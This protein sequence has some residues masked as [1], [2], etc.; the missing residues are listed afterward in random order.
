MALRFSLR[1]RLTLILIAS[2]ASGLVLTGAGLVAYDTTTARA[3]LVQQIEGVT[4]LVAS[5]TDAALTFGDA[6][7]AQVTLS[8]LEARDD[9]IGAAL[10]GR[11]S[12]MVAVHRTASLAHLPPTA[13][14]AG[15]VVEGATVRVVRDI[16]NEGGCVGRLLV[17]ADL[18]LL[19][20]RLRGM[21]AIFAA[22]FV[23]SL[24]LAWALG[25]LM[26]RPVITP[27]RQLSEAAAEVSRSRRFDV[28][29]PAATRGD[30]VGVLITA[31]N[32]M[33][34]EIGSLYGEVRRH[35]D[36]LEQTILLRTSELREAKDRAEAANRYKSEFLA[37]MSHEIR[38]PMNGVLGMTELALE[39]DLAPLQRDYV[40][41][42]RRSA[43]S[44]LSVID[45][46]LDFSK[47]EAGR[48]D[49]EVVPFTLSAVVDD[50][51][52]ALAV[53]AHQRGLDLVCDPAPG[54]PDTILGDQGRLRQVLINLLGNAIKFTMAG[55]VQLQVRLGQGPVGDARLCF[56]VKD[57]G[58]G[59]PADRQQA[60]FEAFTQAD[61]STTR[62]FG[63]TGLGLTISA[64]LVS[65]MGGALSVES[66]EG[67]GST[68]SFDLPLLV[69]PA[70]PR[71]HDLPPTTFAGR[72]IVVIDGQEASRD[73][74]ARW[75]RG[76]GA[77]VAVVPTVDE[78][79]T[80]LEGAACVFVDGRT[81][82][83]PRWHHRATAEVGGGVVGMLTTADAP[84][85]SGAAPTSMLV[86]PLRR[87]AVAAAVSAMLDV[88]RRRPHDAERTAVPVRQALPPLVRVLVAEDNVVNQRVV[89][90]MLRARSCEVIVAN[91]GREA[92]DAWQRSIFDVVF[93]DVQMPEMDGFEAV[94][95][96]RA[97]ERTSGRPRVPI[98]A[99]T[100]HA[101]TGDAERCLAAGMDGYLSKPLRRGAL[102]EEMQRLGLDPAGIAQ[103]RSRP[104]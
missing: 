17:V 85:T 5:N 28:A 91:N 23:V 8:S 82:E 61:G 64:R 46:V 90:G 9:V 86:K 69:A 87:A 49:V 2:S 99:L 103:A 74:L 67:Q 95:A 36:G 42:I 75:L 60:I 97:A 16:C 38:T 40:E 89:Q 78:A 1:Q 37:N 47:I 71:T 54:L 57:T 50:A 43:E 44:L 33:V 62:V 58:V 6:D 92:V 68:F 32:D 84:R 59:I 41:T 104:A 21:L 102:D 14:M 55:S 88:E 45:D 39:T 13:P 77:D 81:L 15:T 96:I 93:M 19:Q 98:V 100:A 65:L 4:H 51:L 70:L 35:R 83:D 63:G 73:V 10:Y 27:L 26:Q 29:L 66:V 72:R 7:A 34:R 25:A 79:W 56:A 12:S 30:E 80:L 3:Q 76:W 20:A 52:G 48:L 24:A 101:M 94:A 22:V 11:D 53:R 18:R 31:F